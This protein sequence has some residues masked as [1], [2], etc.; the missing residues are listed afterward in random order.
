LPTQYVGQLLYFKFPSFNIT[1]GGGQALSDAAVYQYTPQGAQ[2]NPATFPL[3]VIADT[4]IQ[5]EERSS[6][7]RRDANLPTE[8]L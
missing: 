5:L 4:A 6:T 7:V 1:G 2:V 8:S 3:H